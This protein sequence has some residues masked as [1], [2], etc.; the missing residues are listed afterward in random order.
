V[1]SNVAELKQTAVRRVSHLRPI[2]R[3]RETFRFERGVEISASSPGYGR[4][5]ENIA[6]HIKATRIR[7]VS[8]QFKCWLF[9]LRLADMTDRIALKDEQSAGH[10]APPRLTNLSL[11]LHHHA[12]AHLIETRGRSVKIRVPNFKA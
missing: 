11:P 10:M 5:E 8:F 3:T 6:S 2:A 4:S 12:D 7:L 9:L 1:C